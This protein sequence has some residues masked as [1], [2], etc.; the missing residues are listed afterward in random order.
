MNW[1]PTERPTSNQLLVWVNEYVGERYRRFGDW[2]T[3]ACEIPKSRASNPN[4]PVLFSV[5]S[6]DS[7]IGDEHFTMAQL[8]LGSQEH[9]YRVQ[10]QNDGNLARSLEKI[11][12]HQE[13]FPANRPLHPEPDQQPQYLGSLP[14]REVYWYLDAQGKWYTRNDE[15]IQP[16][17]DEDARLDD[18][19][20]NEL[21]DDVV[22][23]FPNPL[24]R[25]MIY[26]MFGMFLHVLFDILLQ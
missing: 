12:E 8:G 20:D 13:L 18:H 24:I 17:E 1:S 9:D 14:D 19:Q 15:L 2:H 16:K 4:P 22:S 21:E 26:M 25:T 6:D 5:F 23:F 11:C 7:S 10:H 3:V